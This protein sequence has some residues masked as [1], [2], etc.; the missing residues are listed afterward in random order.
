MT[1]HAEAREILRQIGDQPDD[2]IDLAEAALALAVLELSTAD[3]TGYRRHIQAIVAD[4]AERVDDAFRESDSLEARIALLH[5][6]IGERHGYSGDHDT[7]DDL[8][9]A[10]MMRVIDRRRGL[11]VAL[12]ILYMHAA[13]SQG[14]SIVGLNFPGHF[15]VRVDLGSARAIIDPF[16]EGQVR[17]VVDLRDLLKATAGSA[18]ELSPDHYQPVANRDVLLRLQNNIKLRHLSAHDIPKALEILEGMRLFAPH[19]PALWRE[20]GLLEAHTGKLADA[21]T[22][23]ETFMALSGDEHQRHQTASLIQTLKK[24]L[25]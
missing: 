15:L 25:N 19:E 12:G 18:A 20:T 13:R 21:I 16:N 4:L 2:A 7:Y 6:V 17:S 1:S 9:N 23:L 11:P 5:Q 22:A 14:W 8:Q 24:R 10:N 3:L